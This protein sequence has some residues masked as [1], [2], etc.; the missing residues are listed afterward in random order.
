MSAALLGAMGPDG[1]AAAHRTQARYLAELAT[2]DAELPGMAHTPISLQLYHCLPWLFTDV[3]D[4]ASDATAETVGAAGLL[5]FGYILVIDRLLD[6]DSTA[7]GPE[8]LWA[9]FM[10]ERA[11]TMLA[12][13]LP[14]T[15][16]AWSLMTRYAGQY[17]CAVLRE[18]ELRVAGGETTLE[19]LRA[20]AIGKAALL[21]ATPAVLACAAERV[22]LLGALDESIDL[23]NEAVQTR[24]DLRDWRSDLAAGRPSRVLAA[25]RHRAGSDA[26]TEIIGHQL[27]YEGVAADALEEAAEA[28]SRARALAASVRA[29]RWAGLV[30]VCEAQLRDAAI[31]CRQAARRAARVAEG[32]CQ[33]QLLEACEHAAAALVA[34]QRSDF[35]EGAHRMRFPHALGFGGETEEHTGDVFIR[36]TVGWSLGEL[37]RAG[38]AIDERAIDCN[39]DALAHRKL[40]GRGGWSYFPTL[41]D[42]APD[43]DDLAQVMLAA[44]GADRRTWREQCAEPVRL[45]LTAHRRADGAFET[46][47]DDPQ[48]PREDRERRVRA[49]RQHWGR[50]VDAAVV[51]NFCHALHVWN[52]PVPDDE[53]GVAEGADVRRAA[54]EWI[55]GQQQADGSWTSSWYVGPYYGTWVC[56]RALSPVVERDTAAQTAVLRAEQ[57]LRATQRADGG[58]AQIGETSDPL[59]TA[60]A[61]LA[62]CAC[63]GARRPHEQWVDRAVAFLSLTQRSD[64]RWPAHP[65]IHMNLNEARA[66]L[67][68]RHL[69]HGSMAATTAYAAAALATHTRLTSAGAHDLVAVG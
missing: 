2:L 43:T 30:A 57:F 61:L 54:L 19:E 59:A 36:A 3:V 64:G 67:A 14:T 45:V 20:I 46:W 39:L 26:Q 7:S 25:A 32:L 62:A 37:R 55:C 60:F 4:G 40:P 21:K 56:A 41:P 12:A 58:W 42:L 9:G 44:V 10:H 8:L 69:M 6:G 53:Q 28:C 13:V 17:A 49:A 47:L 29:R 63:D 50:G 23:F 51:A 11:L 34:E 27:F 22:D 66:G 1:Q 65:W 18:R 38:V 33:A 52:P 16:P 24:D 15:T 5:Y 35:S 31:Q 68:A 48:A